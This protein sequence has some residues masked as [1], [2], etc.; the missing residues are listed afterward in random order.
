MIPFAAEY[1]LRFIIPNLRDYPG[2]PPYTQE[3]L[4]ELS[5]PD[6]EQQ[7]KALRA[8][9]SELAVFL[10]YLIETEDILP[11]RAG[12]EANSTTGGI[13]LLSWSA[14]NCQTIGL[15][16]Y[17]DQLPGDTRDLL[18]AYLRSYVLYGKPPFAS[19]SS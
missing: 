11:I 14:G 6:R 5:S 3:E 7:E 8:R 16:A 2:S 15:L 17:V 10:R 1:D 19:P 18:G 4:K 13:S 9:A 12:S